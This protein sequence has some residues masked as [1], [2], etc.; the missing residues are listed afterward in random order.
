MPNLSSS[1]SRPR[2]SG[3]V[4]RARLHTGEEVAVKVQRPNLEATIKGDIIILKKVAN[5]AERFPQLNENADWSGMLREFDTT[6]HE[7]MDYV[8]E[9][10]NAERFQGEF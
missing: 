1:R 10:H 6:I 5:F 4:Y 7:E 8:A 2:R 9:G 3:Q